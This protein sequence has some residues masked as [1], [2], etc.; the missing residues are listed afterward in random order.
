MGS[1]VSSSADQAAEPGRRVVPGHR[2]PVHVEAA[3]AQDLELPLRQL[4]GRRDQ[5]PSSMA[6][7][8]STTYSASRLSETVIPWARRTACSPGFTIALR[9]AS[10]LTCVR[11]IVYQGQGGPIGARSMTHR[12]APRPPGSAQPRRQ[13]MSAAQ[14]QE[15]AKDASLR[16]MSTQTHFDLDPRRLYLNHAAVAPWPRRTVRPWSASPGRT[17]PAGPRITRAGWPWR[18][19]CGR[20]RRRCSGPL[21]ARTWP[22]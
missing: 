15:P 19:G 3:A 2:G 11:S 8:D 6:R 7:T 17:A 14:C 22:W 10:S 4:G 20:P 18:P 13:M 1:A 9:S 12:I 5:A 16:A 21:A